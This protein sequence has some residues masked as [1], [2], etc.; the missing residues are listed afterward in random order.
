MYNLEFHIYR[1]A[2]SINKAARRH[3]RNRLCEIERKNMDKKKLLLFL[4]L[5][6][7]LSYN[8]YSQMIKD[9]IYK[10]Y[11]TEFKSYT[12]NEEFFYL[13]IEK[14]KSFK[15]ITPYILSEFPLQN[16][17]KVQNI[18]KGI[19]EVNKD[20][21]SFIFLNDGILPSGTPYFGPPKLELKINKNIDRNT[22]YYNG[23]ISVMYVKKFFYFKFESIK[24][25]P[26]NLCLGYK[27][28]K[29]LK[30]Y[31]EFDTEILRRI[32]ITNERMDEIYNKIIG[33]NYKID[34]DKNNG[35]WFKVL[36]HNKEEAEIF[37]ESK[38]Y[39]II[40][41][42]GNCKYYLFYDHDNFLELAF[43]HCYPQ[44]PGYFI[45]TGLSIQN[46]KINYTARFIYYG[47]NI[48]RS[49]IEIFN[50]N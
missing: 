45:L 24:N 27:T 34:I 49:K 44:E 19:L 40:A 12:E 10:L 16:D 50:S 28:T 36:F 22:E 8:S 25:M 18:F 39:G 42:T 14:D 11:Y 41:S 37:F 32:K 7:I 3:M 46:N 43:M 21:I 1:E 30:T 35:Y 9:G 31:L 5:I 6:C 15:I 26:L 33:N 2:N 38:E 23:I 20:S 48:P 4:L 17:E 29:L 47:G 13:K